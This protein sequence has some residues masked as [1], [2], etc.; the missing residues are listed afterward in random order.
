M[1]N[2]K[3]Y[4]LDGGTLVIDNSEVFWHIDPGNPVRFPVYSVLVEHQDALILFDTGYDLEHVNKVLPFELPEQ[5]PQQT[6]PAQLALCGYMPE[7]VDY[8]INSH[9]HFDHVGG[10]KY[11]TNATTL[12]HKDELRHAKVPESFERLGYSDLSFDYPGVKYQQISGDY[13]VVP[14]VRLFETPGHTSGHYSMLVEMQDGPSMLFAG[15]AAYTNKTLEAEIIGGFHLDPT[16]SVESIRRLN[17]LGRTRGAD[18]YPSHEL[19]PFQTWKLAP[20]YYGG[21]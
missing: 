14:G 4:L 6:I 13:D 11:L 1:A 7:D 10:N 15:D 16:D 19:E 21:N 20:S 17:Y 12:V 3:V 2:P 9:L 8:V 18:I 5:T